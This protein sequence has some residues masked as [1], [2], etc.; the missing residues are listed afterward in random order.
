MNAHYG[1]LA[2]NL[3]MSTIIMYLVM[4][5]MIDNLGA[6]FN[7]LNMLYMALMMVA[8][9]AILMLLL[10]RSMY[11]NRTANLFLHAFFAVVFIVAF[12][13]IRGQTVIG[14]E[15]FL[16]SMI[17]HHSGAILMCREATLTDPEIIDLC[18]AIIR[19]QRDE[20]EQ[21]ERILARY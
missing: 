16:R 4:F 3:A 6:F 21:M 10:M 15:Q 14:D 2:I 13:F 18:Q 17:P 20:I 12:L 1:K 19:S 11:P 9:M 8:P 5:A 7:N